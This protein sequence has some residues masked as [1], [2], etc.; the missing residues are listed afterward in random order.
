MVKIFF[1]NRVVLQ[2][3][4]SLNLLADWE[5]IRHGVPQASVLGPLLF[6]MYINNFPC[7]IN[8]IYHNILF[9]DDT[10]ILVS[11]SDLNEINAK[12]NSILCCIS[13]SVQNKQLVLNLNKMHIVKFASSKLLTYPLNTVHNNQALIV[14]ENIKFL[15]KHLDCILTWKSHID[16]LIKK[17]EFNLLCVEK[18][19]THCKCKSVTYGLFCTFLSTYQLVFIFINEKYF[20]NSK[21][22]N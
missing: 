2:F 4:S 3:V 16:N 8:K 22:S 13:K 7:I 19:I 1:H 5:I 20:C 6:N 17:T 12:L 21:K 9:A 15:G 18:I 11:S 10:N 14:T